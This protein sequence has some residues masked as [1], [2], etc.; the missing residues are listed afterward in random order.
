MIVTSDRFDPE[1]LSRLGVDRLDHRPR[2]LHVERSIVQ[3][4]VPDA[5]LAPIHLDLGDP[6][7]GQAVPGGRRLGND[8]AVAVGLE[9]SGGAEYGGEHNNRRQQSHNASPRSLTDGS[10]DTP[11]PPL[12]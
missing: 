10:P 7:P 4:D 1:R 9:P 6:R 8:I 11:L 12:S 5:A 2:G 3:D